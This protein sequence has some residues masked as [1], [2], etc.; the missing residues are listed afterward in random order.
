VFWFVKYSISFDTCFVLWSIRYHSISFD[1]GF[2]LFLHQLDVF[3]AGSH[4]QL[5]PDPTCKQTC[6][7][8][9]CY[10][11][12]REKST[13]WRLV[14]L[15]SSLIHSYACTYLLW[16]VGCAKLED[17]YAYKAA[18]GYKNKKFTLSYMCV[19]D[20]RKL[21]KITYK[22]TRFRITNNTTV[23]GKQTWSIKH[24]LNGQASACVNMLNKN[25]Q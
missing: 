3:H 2:V 16:N 7:N 8:T 20:T 10:Q 14:L 15:S 17:V 23:F 12:Q 22:I 6:V 11:T 13:R 4:F 19:L 5:N 21:F 25:Q 24:P 1:K 9:G 18:M